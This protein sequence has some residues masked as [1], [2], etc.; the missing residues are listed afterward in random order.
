MYY[1]IRMTQHMPCW[2]RSLTVFGSKN[3]KHC[4][5]REGT[6]KPSCLGEEDHLSRSRWQ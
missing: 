4:P 6:S 1:F 5:S 2:I 3:W